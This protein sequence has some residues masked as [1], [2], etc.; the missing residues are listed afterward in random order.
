MPSILAAAAVV[1]NHNRPGDHEKHVG[2]AEFVLGRRRNRWF[3][4]AD[5]IVAEVAHGA[6]EERGDG[7]IG[8]HAIRGH[9]FLQLIEWI[10]RGLER[11]VRAAF[12]DRDGFSRGGESGLRAEAEERVA[13]DLVVLLGGLEQEGRRLAAELRERGHRRVGIGDDLAGDRQHA[14]R[15]RFFQKHRP[16]RIQRNHENE[17]FGAWR[18]AA[19][20]TWN[21]SAAPKLKRPA[22]RLVGKTSR[23]VL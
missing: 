14:G 7:R 2:N 22:M 12:A 6:A 5:A 1:E 3:E 18:S 19:L 21:N 11:T 20:S 8:R 10:A 9:P 4:P 16:G 13:A 17:T 23:F 15:G